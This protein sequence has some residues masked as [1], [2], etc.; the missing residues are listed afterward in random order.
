MLS[1]RDALQLLSLMSLLSDGISDH[2]LVQSR[3]PIPEIL[4]CKA[5]LLCTSL[6]YVDQA[7][8]L[9]LLAPIREYIRNSQPPSLTL[10]WLCKARGALTTGRM[11]YTCPGG[12]ECYLS[13]GL[14]SI[15]FK[16]LPR[17]GYSV[18]LCG[19]LL[20]TLDIPENWADCRLS[21]PVVIR[22]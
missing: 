18:L 13:G 22:T 14:M 6:A 15:L 2:D 12:I 21:W 4:K 11:L 20:R 17:A 8:Q 16:R 9:K 1:L 10:V 5:T 7:G 3:P 19:R